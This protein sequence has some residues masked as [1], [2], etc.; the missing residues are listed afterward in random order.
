[1]LREILKDLYQKPINS[2]QKLSI[3]YIKSFILCDIYNYFAPIKLVY[4]LILACLIGNWPT[5][6]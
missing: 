5:H 1:M 6:R 2:D 4:R 3:N